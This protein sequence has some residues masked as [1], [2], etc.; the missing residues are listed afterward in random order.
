MKRAKKTKV[1]VAQAELVMQE[2]ITAAGGG[3][4]PASVPLPLHTGVAVAAAPVA[5]DKLQKQLEAA[6]FEVYKANMFPI[7]MIMCQKELVKAEKQHD[8][9]LRIYL[10]ML[11]SGAVPVGA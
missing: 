8:L 11:G 10:V 4:A 5:A 3:Q 6:Q 9:N 1:E 7:M 2:R